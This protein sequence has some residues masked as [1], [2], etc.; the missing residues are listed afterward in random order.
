MRKRV[1]LRRKKKPLDDCEVT[2]R[3]S[4]TE[5]EMKAADEK[6]RTKARKDVKL[7][8][9]KKPDDSESSSSTTTTSSSSDSTHHHA[10]SK[11]TTTLRRYAKTQNSD[12]SAYLEKTTLHNVTF[13]IFLF[14]ALWVNSADNLNRQTPL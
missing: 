14:F 1:I 11:H 7:F 13:S 10:P 4:F 9:D 2:F 12:T 6:H 5:D 3:S 8:C